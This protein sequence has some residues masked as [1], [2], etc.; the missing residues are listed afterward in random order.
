VGFAVT[1][2]G[3]PG[4]WIVEKQLARFLEGSSVTEIERMWDQMYLSTLRYGR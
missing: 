1:T 4:A 3:E 2:G